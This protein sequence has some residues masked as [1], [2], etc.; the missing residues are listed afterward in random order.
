V[1]ETFNIKGISEAYNIFESIIGGEMAFSG[2]FV[3]RQFC[4]NIGK[5]DGDTAR[6]NVKEVTEEWS[7]VA[8]GTTV[9]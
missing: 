8:G 5:G 3:G 7:I 6:L 1:A 2:A 9:S 4:A